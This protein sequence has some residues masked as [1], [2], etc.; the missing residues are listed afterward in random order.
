LV[1]TGP[2]AECGVPWWG[3][4][5]RTLG[6]FTGRHSLGEDR[7]ET[8]KLFV[9]QWRRRIDK[10][11]YVGGEFFAPEVAARRYQFRIVG[12]PETGERGDS[13]LP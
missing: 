7:H 11:L 9:G 1:V 10:T 4:R 12:R 6:S 13:R 5:S 8:A 2:F 3:R